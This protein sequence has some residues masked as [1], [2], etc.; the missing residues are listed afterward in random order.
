M[1]VASELGSSWQQTGVETIE[2]GFIVPHR[3]LIVDD[4]KIARQGLQVLLEASGEF[5]IVGDTNGDGAIAMA[6]DR[7]PNVVIMDL[8]VPDVAAGMRRLCQLRE[9]LTD[10]RVIIFAV[11]ES[12]P[13]LIY[14]AI[15][16]GAAG[17]V[18]K[19]HSDIDEV[20]TAIRTVAD[21][22]VF[23]SS[24]A[25]AVLVQSIQ[26]EKAPPSTSPTVFGE[27]LTARES[28]VLNL[29]AQGLTNRQIADRLAISE[30]TARSHLHNILDKLQVSNRVQAAAYVLR[31]R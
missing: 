26:E 12:E 27:R 9:S 5:Q 2:T 16:H 22:Q 19:S 25:L 21:G 29:V 13:D 17:Y 3:V 30:S 8:R 28:D 10:A 24:A 15:R 6:L 14:R 20:A 1:R 31:L 18:L 7:R 4:Q 23:I 11:H